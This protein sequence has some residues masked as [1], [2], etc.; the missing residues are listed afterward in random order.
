MIDDEL[1]RMSEDE[2]RRRFR[3]LLMTTPRGTRASIAQAVHR[4]YPTAR[5]VTDEIEQTIKPPWW[6]F[7]RTP[8]CVHRVDVAI[9][10]YRSEDM[11]GLRLPP[12]VY[13]PSST[14]PDIAVGRHFEVEDELH[15]SRPAGIDLRVEWR[16][17]QE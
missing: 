14:A 15:Q 12:S 6:A 17:A 7:W 13:D 5:V 8:R 10:L 16:Y 2:L 4:Y 9:V 1:P 3:D 11:H